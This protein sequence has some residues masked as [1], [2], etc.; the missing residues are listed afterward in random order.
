M[1][2]LAT[3]TA[4]PTTPGECEISSAETISTLIQSAELEFQAT[5]R[6]LVERARFLT[7]ASGAAIALEEQGKMVY[8]AVGGDP[9]SSAG[10]TVDTSK[11]PIVQCIERGKPAR[12][13]TGAGNALFALAAPIIKDEKVI[14]LFELY[15]QSTFEDR[16][17]ESMVRLAEMV[18]TAIDHRKAA[19]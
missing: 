19:E 4:P 5:L 8:C 3:T 7:A 2:V 15:R 18:N 6:L 14:G 17:V 1:E 9:V 10:A 13:R 11:E 12:S 16:D